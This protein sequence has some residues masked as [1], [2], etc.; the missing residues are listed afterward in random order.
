MP[1]VKLTDVPAY[2]KAVGAGVTGAA[3][4]VTAA[5]VDGKLDITDVFIIIG[6]FVV[7]LVAVF[8]IPNAEPK[9]SPKDDAADDAAPLLPPV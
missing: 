8:N 5:S 9:I 3:A 2:L 1:K 7:P 4:A 6:A